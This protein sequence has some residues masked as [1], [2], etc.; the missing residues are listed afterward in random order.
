[1][2]LIYFIARSS[3]KILG[4]NFGAF[5]GNADSNVKKYIGFALLPQVG[6]ALAL[7]LSIK[8]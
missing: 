6:V 3:G 2:G 4:G 7:A 5:L 1:M 8:K